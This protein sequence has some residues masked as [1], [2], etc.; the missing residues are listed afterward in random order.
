M[1]ETLLSF[2]GGVNSGFELYRNI[3]GLFRGD[4]TNLILQRLDALHTKYEKL[5]SGLWY[6]PSI[7]SVVDTTRTEQTVLR[8]PRTARELLQPIQRALK[9]DVVA[10]GLINTPTRLLTKM[11]CNPFDLFTNSLPAEHFVRPS[12]PNMVPVMFEYN[13]VQFI[14][15]QTRG[16]LP[17]LFDCEMHDLPGLGRA[18][19]QP[20]KVASAS[21][22]A[23]PEPG[24]EFCDGPGLPL[25]VVIPAG[26][27]LMGSPETER[28]RAQDEGPQRK[29]TIA[30]PF[31]VGKYAVTFDEWDASAKEGGCPSNP[32]PSD[33]G[34]ERGTR[35]VINVRWDDAQEYVT[36][37][38]KKTGKT[39]RLLSEAEWEYA[40][41]AGTTTPFSFGETISTAQANYRGTA[42]YGMGVEGEDR[43]KTMPVG[44]FPA[45]AFGLHEMHGNVWEWVQDC[46]GLYTE[47]PSDGSAAEKANGSN[48]VLRG[49]CWGNGP[50]ALRSANR[51][52][53]S[54][55]GRYSKFGFRVARTL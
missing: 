53:N 36:W 38:S 20:I 1:I 37:L 4:R 51:F 34:W 35:P 7:L 29:V 21:Q 19:P 33:E 31:A 54:F 27:F 17:M 44:S 23:D 5:E 22:D 14:G 48:R 42:T 55:G 6:A 45:N 16:A 3:T 2:A 43:Q 41:R 32:N 47:A 39:Y 8:D 30:R 24:T 40:C 25:M 50:K 15:W 46:Y 11:K 10:S 9:T 28:K 13:G 49:G 18:A 12:D 26:T 52:G